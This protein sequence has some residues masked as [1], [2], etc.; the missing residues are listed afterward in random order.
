MKRR[1]LD[2]FLLAFMVVLAGNLL[3]LYFVGCW[4]DTIKFIEYTEVVALFLLGI[5]SFVRVV[6]RLKEMKTET[7]NKPST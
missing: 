4:Y 5:V 6:M 7:D 2:T 1:I 3:Y